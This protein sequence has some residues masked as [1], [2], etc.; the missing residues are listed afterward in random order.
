MAEKQDLYGATRKQIA[1]AIRR[2]LKTRS[3]E[4]SI[5]GSKSYDEKLPPFDLATGF[6]EEP[7]VTNKAPRWI[8]HLVPSAGSLV[9]RMPPQPE[10]TRLGFYNTANQPVGGIFVRVVPAIQ[11]PDG[12]YE[13]YRVWEW[14]L[15]FAFA[16]A[17]EAG[18]SAQL[19]EGF[20]PSSGRIRYM[21][22]DQ[23]YIAAG[24][25]MLC[26]PKLSYSPEGG[27]P[28]AITYQEATEALA[29]LIHVD[30]KSPQSREETV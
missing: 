23:P 10:A 18:S 15:F 1:S 8:V 25:F 13:L 3:L 19:V 12:R 30:L 5:C 16:G 9:A 4:L 26:D 27:A 20:D 21:N 17:L 2:V 11:G 24:L 28:S 14:I 6:W 29:R 22:H 7:A